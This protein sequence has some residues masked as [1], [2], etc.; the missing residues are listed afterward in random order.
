M[1]FTNKSS[2]FCELGE[3]SLCSEVV[4]LVTYGN[5]EPGLQCVS[6]IH[7]C[8]V[9]ETRH[10]SNKFLSRAQDQRQCAVRGTMQ[11]NAAGNTLDSLKFIF[12]FCFLCIQKPF[13]ITK[14]PLNPT[15]S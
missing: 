11:A 7:C 9:V 8:Y 3:L 4:L 5:P 10:I 2:G 15:I 6:F 12:K 13:I 14:S 1:L